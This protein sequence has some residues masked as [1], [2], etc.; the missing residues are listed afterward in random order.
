VR[1]LTKK[2]EEIRYLR[3]KCRM[4]EV[5]RALEFSDFRWSE[6][7]V[8][9]TCVDLLTDWGIFTERTEENEGRIERENFSGVKIV[10]A[11]TC[12]MNVAVKIVIT[13]SC[14]EKVDN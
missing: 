5:K 3:R 11:R 9:G 8:A 7:V 14:D 6:L 1:R 4:R 12:D 13:G 2:K 10:N